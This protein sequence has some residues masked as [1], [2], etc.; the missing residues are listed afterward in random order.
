LSYNKVK[1][2]RG[3]GIPNTSDLVT[4]ELGYDYTNNKLYIHDGDSGSIV[5]VGGSTITTAAVSNGATT[6]ATG[7]HIY[8][9]VVGQGYLTSVPN[10]SAALLTSGTV[11]LAR[12]SGLTTDNIASDAA[13]EASK[14]GVLPASKITSGT[15]AA[16][17]IPDSFLKNNADD[18]TSGTIT[19]GGFTTAGNIT[20]SGTVDGRDVASDGSKLDGIESGATAD[21]TITLTGD[22]TGSGTGSFATTIVDDSHNHSWLNSNTGDPGDSRLQYWQAVNNTTLNPNSNWFT[23]IRMGHGD[24]V[25]YYSNTIAVQMTGTGTGDLY[26]RNITG[27]TAGNWFKHWNDGNDGSGSGLDADLLDGQ[28]GSYYA[29]ASKSNNKDYYS[30]ADAAGSYLGG[31]YSSGGTEK[32]N[33]G[34]FGAGKFKVAMLAGS[35]LGFGGTWNDVMWVSAYN[36]GDVKSSHALVFD[37]GSTNVYV[38]DQDYDSASWGTGYKLWHSGNDGAGSGLDADLLDGLQLE[39]SGRNDNANKVVRTDSNGYLT[40]GWINTPSGNTT[41]ASSDYYVNTNDGYIRKKTLANVRTEIMGVSSGASFL[42]S[43]ATSG[44]IT[45]QDWNT[46]VN[47]TEVH[48][49]SVTNHSGSNRP[50]GAYHYGVALSYSVASGGKFQLYAPETGSLGTATNQGLWYRTGWNTT[51]RQWAQIWDST[52]DGSGSGLDADL[53]DGVQGSSF[54]RSDTA[55]TISAQLTMGTQKALVA[56]NYGRGVYGLY[57]SGRYQ[58]VWSMGTAYNLADDGTTSGNLYGLSFTHTNAGGQSKPGLSHQLLVMDNGVT[59]SAIGNGIWTNG[60]ITMALS[61]RLYLDGGTNDWIS[62]NGNNIISTYVNGNE[63]LRVA[64]SYT[65]MPN[66]IYG[67]DGTEAAPMYNFWNDQIL[68]CIE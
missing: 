37:K 39:T 57:N 8:D 56:N 66:K 14:I 22:V 38:S 41:T 20:V 44:T 16:A 32:P 23:A 46:Y 36:G 60:H 33:D 7:D 58:H 52:N 4:Y 27:G 1:I 11:P 54:L 55:D 62:T 35:N 17:R 30:T 59:K 40:V 53:L 2:R 49:S 13:I 26:T 65:Y 21:Q 6:L 34:T 15:F 51:Y 12:I 48:F 45:S 18:T 64:D 24:P 31:H 50:S 63:R 42:R 61:K 25:T 19:A 3:S 28:Q 68:V 43:D 10:H 5:E 67:G 47:G 29:Q 9:F